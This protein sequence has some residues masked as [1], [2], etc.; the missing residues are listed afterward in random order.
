MQ[1]VRAISDAAQMA[2]QLAEAAVKKA[3]TIMD[4][5]AEKR[6]PTEYLSSQAVKRIQGQ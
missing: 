4:A 1:E 5:A 2:G 3:W 6:T